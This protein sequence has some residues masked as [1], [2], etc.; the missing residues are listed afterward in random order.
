M[1]LVVDASMALAWLFERT[2]KTEADCADQAL[3]CLAQAEVLVPALWHTEV[4][5]ALLVGERRR[6]VTEAQVIDYLS[7]LSALPIATD[8]A[9]PASRRD[10]IM[11]LA[12]EHRLTAYDA[13]YLDL[14]LRTGAILATFDVAL[15]DAMRRAGGIV[16]GDAGQLRENPE[17]K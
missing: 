10:G 17:S 15:A 3:L 4:A 9:A 16:F 11:A 13:T 14:A 1:K 2:S 12:R 7:K 5:N 8:S 6:V